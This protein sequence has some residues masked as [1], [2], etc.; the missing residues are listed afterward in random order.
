M[1]QLYR[2]I[3]FILPIQ[4]LDKVY[5]SIIESFVLVRIEWR[6]RNQLPFFLSCNYRR[7][8][9]NHPY[10]NVIDQRSFIFTVVIILFRRRAPTIRQRGQ[11]HAKVEK[12]ISSSPDSWRSLSEEY[13]HDC[14]DEGALVNDDDEAGFGDNDSYNGTLGDEGGESEAGLH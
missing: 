7:R 3:F 6:C 10:L 12:Y 5:K 13:N 9:N 4:L 14:K 8:W 1:V 2:S 11:Q